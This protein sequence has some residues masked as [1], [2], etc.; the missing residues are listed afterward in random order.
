MTM[1]WSSDSTLASWQIVESTREARSG[2][3]SREMH[4]GATRQDEM[5]AR[6]KQ[7]RKLDENKQVCSG[8]H[9]V[10]IQLGIRGRLDTKLSICLAPVN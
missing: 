5:N 6:G 7:G 1:V 9:M 3:K 10:K 4:C 2:V 8:I